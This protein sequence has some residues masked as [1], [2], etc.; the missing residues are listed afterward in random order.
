M[1][2][3]RA[4]KWRAATAARHLGYLYAPESR[5]AVLSALL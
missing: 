3:K 1:A 2:H 4:Q 5:G